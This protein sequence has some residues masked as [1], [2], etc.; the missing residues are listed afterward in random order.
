[1]KRNLK[2]SSSVLHE[3]VYMGFVRPQIEYGVAIWDP[4]PGVEYNGAHEIERVQRRAARWTLK[5]Y[6]Y[7]SSVSSML[8]DLGWRSLEQRREDA[9]STKDMFLLRPQNTFGQ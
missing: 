5:R 2:I 7:T 8:P 6:H 3:K 4:K 1:M 9:R